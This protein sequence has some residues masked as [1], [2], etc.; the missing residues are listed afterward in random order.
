MYFLLLT[1][2]LGI[3]ALHIL[4]VKHP[5]LAKLVY[6]VKN[7]AYKFH[8]LRVA[9]DLIAVSSQCSIAFAGV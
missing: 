9:C 1:A 2:N 5:F 6:V 8:S 7:L 4:F 3:G